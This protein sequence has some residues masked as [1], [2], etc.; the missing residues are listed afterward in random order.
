MPDPTFNVGAYE[1]PTLADF[2]DLWATIQRIISTS[3]NLRVANV[4]TFG[5]DPT[6]VADSQPAFLAAM[7]SFGAV[8]DSR[9]GIIWVP[10][11]KFRFASGLSIKKSVW[12]LGS[13]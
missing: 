6:G 11:G 7:N 12:I 2:N 9:G 8:G 13:Q 3:N 10:F 5:A 4:L 1:V